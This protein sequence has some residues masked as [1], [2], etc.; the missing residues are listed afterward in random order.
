VAFT[1]EKGS[2]VLESQNNEDAPVMPDT[3]GDRQSTNGEQLARVVTEFSRPPHS[4]IYRL[5]WHNSGEPDPEM[6]CDGNQRVGQEETREFDF[7][8]DAANNFILVMWHDH[9][10][11]SVISNCHGIEPLRSATR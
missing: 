4:I 1:D 6:S 10:V 7:R 3:S 9:A 11:V 2:H 5:H 8:Q